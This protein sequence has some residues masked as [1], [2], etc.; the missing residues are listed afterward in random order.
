MRISIIAVLLSLFFSVS[1]QKW[2]D[3]MLDT[4]SNFFEVQSEF[5]KELAKDS[6][7]KIHG[8]KQFKRWEYFMESRVDHDGYFRHQ[9]ATN[10]FYRDYANN[11]TSKGSKGAAGNW[12]QIG[13]F[14]A[15]SGSGSG[16]TNCIAFHPINS[17]YILIGTASGG[18]WRSYNDGASWV[19]NTDGLENLGIS[20]IAFSP[21][22]PNIVYAATGDRDGG[23]TYSVGLL[24]SFDSGFTWHP[25]G[26][27]YTQ[28]AKRK[29]YKILVHPQNDSI[30]FLASSLGLRK[31]LDGGNTWIQI[32][33]GSFV[34]AEFKPNDPNTIY[35]ATNTIVIRSVDGGIT[36]TNLTIPFVSAN[37][38]LQ[39]AVT[40]A[41]A[42]YVYVL[43][44]N[45]SDNGFGG[46]YRSVDGGT[47]FALRASSPNL[48]G[49]NKNGN[50]AG[51]QGWYDLALGVSQTNPNL[52]FVGGV[53]IWKSANGGT[54]WSLSGHWTGNNAP[55]VH[56]DIHELKFSPHNG[57][58]VWACTDG[59]LSVSTSNGSNWTE[60]NTDLSIAQMYRMGSSASNANLILTGWQD[61]GTNFNNNNSWGKVIG[62]DGMECFI[63]YSNN[64]YMYGSLYY[65]DIRRSTNGGNSWVGIT[66]DLQ[67]S[68]A[69][70]TPY[71][72][73]PNSAATL[74]VGY[75]D[76]FKSTNRGTSW[77]KIS[78]FGATMNLNAL[79]VAP[80]NS[81]YI[82]AANSYALFMTSNGG[83]T[84][85]NITSPNFNQNS[86]SYIAIHA[87]NPN[88][89]WVTLSGYSNGYKVFQ[90]ND[91]GQTWT[92]ISGTLPNLPAN[93]IVHEKNS[94][95][96][97]YVGL[98]VGVFYRDTVIGDWVPFMK[99]L[100]NV[101][102]KELEF[103]YPGHKIRAATFG[104]G[105]WESPIYSLANSI[106]DD[107]NEN[108]ESIYIGPNPSN[109]VVNLRLENGIF[110][111]TK[112][113]IFNASGQI[114]YNAFISNTNNYKID[115][116][117]HPKGI[118]FIKILN[119]D[120]TVS[121]K[122]II[123]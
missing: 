20:D 102:V 92:N 69:W 68:G 61:N 109:G 107:K 44:A 93:T 74:Y 50:D 26:L 88:K 99:N 16:R 101:I 4:N 85:T 49:W 10:D 77:T 8:F 37:R 89:A 81:N 66:D 112:I 110:I 35:A 118:Y 29:I 72:Q 22:N 58:T 64:N 63:D 115:L 108:L 96:G 59:G 25:T 113:E 95:D 32:R 12:T 119:N 86:I 51:G 87:T 36:W 28:N 78:N 80:S 75:Q 14:G 73:D 48:L 98:D 13:P 47:T 76:V 6:T 120:I 111:N 38:R 121:R 105:L 117:N 57:T 9:S 30:I 34:D 70:V 79:S 60:K 83:S 94:P 46:L 33:A 39:I 27:T 18:I 53:N 2:I 5:Y 122:L 91:A 11:L 82:Y 3:L 31:S 15:P 45:S 67:E 123:N 21:S 90:T 71:I 40:A 1:G 54:S 97:L 17:G 84:W 24:K 7:G 23:D 42:N 19:T 65:G 104:R 116:V 114:I 103:Y 56:A 62:G 100:P 41:D 52:I 43:A 55:Y 106:N